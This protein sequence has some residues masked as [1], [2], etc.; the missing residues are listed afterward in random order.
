MIYLNK[1]FTGRSIRK[2]ALQLHRQKAFELVHGHETYFG[3]EAGP[4]GKL[5]GIPSVFTLHGFYEEH[6]RTFGQAFMK[7]VIKN[8][9]L[10]NRLLTDS[11]K[12]ANTYQRFLTAP[13]TPIPNGLD[14][15]PAGALPEETIAF[16]NRR[17]YLLSVGALSPSKHFEVSVRALAEVHQRGHS[18]YAL[19][20]VGR[21]TE[22]QKIRSLIKELHLENDVQIISGITR[23]EIRGLFEQSEIVLHPSIVEAFCIVVLEGLAAGKAVVA[24]TNIGIMDYLR[25]G[26][27]IIAVPPSPVTSK[28]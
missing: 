2:L 20:M 23:P 7:Q 17:P 13:F 19:V 25:P 6:L 9:H 10:V 26:Q 12:A 1:Y 27:D 3:D 5:L 15:I 11:M 22:E 28:P 16:L 24:T 14:A 21:G 18:E 4:I 8:L